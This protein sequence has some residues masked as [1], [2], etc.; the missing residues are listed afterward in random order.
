MKIWI[1]GHKGMLGS[2]ILK[3]INKKK[4]Q[5]LKVTKKQLDLINQKHVL[6]WCSKNKPDVIVHC[7]A[8]VG[9]INANSNFPVD[10]LYQ[11]TAMQLNVLNAAY[12]N[13]IRKL[14]MLGSSCSYPPNTKRPILEKDLLADKPE[15]T[16]IWYSVAK[17][18]GIKLCEAYRKQFGFNYFSIIPTNLYGPGDTFNTNNNH[19]IPSLIQKIY[20][21]KLKRLDKII[22]WGSGK[23]LRDFMYIDDAAKIILHFM[24]KNKKYSL[25]N[26]GTGKEINIKNLATKIA[27]IIGYKGRIE[28]DIKKPDGAKRKLLD[29]SRLKEYGF[30]NFTNLDHGLKMTYKY[31]K[32]KII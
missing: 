5:V 12:K 24:N 25:I 15:I 16:N 27:S 30:K 32:N 8:K 1:T 18:N 21:A 7:A 19:V 10:F 13:N 6:N 3:N 14:I 11:N 2:A 17:I 26:I 31:Y 23:P 9:G 29:I 4:Y 20:L 28:F 22:L